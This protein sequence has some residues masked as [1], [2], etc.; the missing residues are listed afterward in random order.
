MSFILDALRKAESARGA[1]DTAPSGDSA[2]AHIAPV[3]AV[4][5]RKPLLTAFAVSAV[6]AIG[7]AGWWFGR[8][9]LPPVATRAAVEPVAAPALPTDTTRRELRPLDR[10]VR[11]AQTQTRASAAAPAVAANAGTVITPGTVEVSSQP[12][13]ASAVDPAPRTRPAAAAPQPTT[14]NLPSYDDLVLSRRVQLPRLHLDIHVYAAAPERRF[15]FVNNRKYREGERL[16]EGGRVEL[17]TPAGVVVEH[18]GHRFQL[19]PD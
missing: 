17:I 7:V 5:R 3:Q 15:V 1:P 6:F 8:Q 10:E 12:L 2:L 18:L 9:S 19:L 16:D 4:S 14:D 13:S 11:R